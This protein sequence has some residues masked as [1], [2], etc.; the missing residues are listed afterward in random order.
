MGS[1]PYQQRIGTHQTYS[2]AP[3]ARNFAGMA[4]HM[5][6]FLICIIG[7]LAG[8][9]TGA[10]RRDLGTAM[11]GLIVVAISIAGMAG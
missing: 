4:I 2:P 3:S 8:A 1:N 9:I 11:L 5:T 7:G 6:L 10:Y